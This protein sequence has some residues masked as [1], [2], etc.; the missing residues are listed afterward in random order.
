VGLYP[1]NPTPEVAYL[2]GHSGAK[3][4]L[5]EDQEQV[6][7]ALAVAD[8]LPDLAHIV[9][10][11]PRGVRTYDDPRLMS[12]DELVALGRRH[13]A[14]REGEV[15]RRMA[16]TAPEDIMTL[17]YTSG[18]TGAP[19]G[20]PLTHRNLAFQINAVAEANVVTEDDRV[21]L[22]LPLHHVYP[23]VVGTLTPL[24]LGLTIVMLTR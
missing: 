4:L 13:R 3:L 9:Y 18:T 24:A 12:W 20:V 15:E 11:E 17:F 1:T 16:E 6:D 21:L 10:V 5:A 2:L 8:E 14:A 23:F 7:K 22:P 19:K